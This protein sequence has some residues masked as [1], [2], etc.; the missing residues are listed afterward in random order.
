MAATSPRTCWPARRAAPV[1][2][3]RSGA[4]RPPPPHPHRV[5]RAWRPCAH[6]DGLTVC[7]MDEGRARSF[8]AAPHAAGG[9]AVT[10]RGA[11]RRQRDADRVLATWSRVTDCIGEATCSQARTFTSLGADEPGKG[12]ALAALHE[13]A[14]SSSTTR[15]LAVTSW[16]LGTAGR[17]RADAAG[18]FSEGAARRRRPAGTRRRR[19]GLHR[20]GMPL[21]GPRWLGAYSP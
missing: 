13:S 19:Y 16:A 21:A 8:A 11:A 14:Q 9:P 15:A 3:H 1:A 6:R 4:G 20:S 12:G 10:R 7:E 5:L 18:T 2:V 17:R